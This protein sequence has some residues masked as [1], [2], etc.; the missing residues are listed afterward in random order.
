[1]E[2]HRLY[3][4]LLIILSP[5]LLL[6]ADESPTKVWQSVL[7]ADGP[8]RDGKD[9]MQVRQHR[10]GELSRLAQKVTDQEIPNGAVIATSTERTSGP[11]LM[12]V[13]V[14]KLDGQSRILAVST[15]TRKGGGALSLAHSTNPR[16][17]GA[18][19]R[20]S[21]FA[22]LLLM[23]AM[24]GDTVSLPKSSAVVTDSNIKN[25]DVERVL[26][27]LD[28]NYGV[29]GG[30]Y[31]VYS[32]VVLFANGVACKCLESAIDEI[33]VR[34]VQRNTPKKVGKWQKSG[35][36]YQVSWPGAKKPEIL[37]ITV[38]PPVELPGVNAL[39]GTYQSIGGGGNTAFGGNVQVAD[40]QDLTFHNDGSFS[41]SNATLATSGAGTGWS[42]KGS[43]GSWTLS[44][45]TLT[46]EYGDGKTVRTTV[47]YSKKRKSSA[48][49]GRYGVLWI[50]GEDFK[51]I[52]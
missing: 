6:G 27:D 20:V 15:A 23:S 8:Y 17:P 4:L 40:V 26:F 39:D 12:R 36:N 33:D 51:R 19:E 3:A 21:E 28:Y 1:M 44:G 50:G 31:P 2:L 11:G 30:A 43:T 35:S 52:R 37:K 16:M 46:L 13:T 41:Q 29:G 25:A 42:K 48:S 14:Y 45:S 9:S 18:S 22:G 34:R 38:G 5:N 47:F 7:E 32:P 49:F 10:D 24:K